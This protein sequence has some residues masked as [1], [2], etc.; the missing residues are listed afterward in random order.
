MAADNASLE[1]PFVFFFF[2]T[3]LTVLLF[4]FL[5]ADEFALSAGSPSDS[6]HGAPAHHAMLLF[7]YLFTY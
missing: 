1:L 7:A 3:F 6:T 2:F 4:F 5:V